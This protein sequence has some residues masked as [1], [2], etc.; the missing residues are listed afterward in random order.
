MNGKVV[1]GEKPRGHQKLGGIST[2]P[3]TWKKA[4]SLGGE[5]TGQE[6]CGKEAENAAE[7]RPTL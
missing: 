6:G 3:L 1:N 4:A 7:E 2:A 5:Y